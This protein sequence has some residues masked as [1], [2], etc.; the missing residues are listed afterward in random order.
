MAG[1]LK[2]C[3]DCVFDALGCAI[4]DSLA[5][6]DCEYHAKADHKKMAALQTKVSS[7]SW[8]LP[9]GKRVTYE[10]GPRGTSVKYG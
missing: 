5:G 1:K 2:I 4:Q 6:P 8:T 3:N 7:I 9:N 10:H